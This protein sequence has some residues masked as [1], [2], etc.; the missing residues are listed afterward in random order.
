MHGWI[1]LLGA[2]PV[3]LR[4]LSV[5]FGF[6]AI[7]AIY[8]AAR[9]LFGGSRVPL[10]AAFLLA[11]NPM[12]VFYSQEVRMYGFV[13]LL[14]I[15]ILAA[16]WRVLGAADTADAAR[17]GLKPRSDTDES[18]LKPADEEETNPVHRVS[19][20]SARR[21]NAGRPGW[22]ALL[23]YVL[24]TT[25]ALYTQYYAVFLPVGLTFYALWHWRRNGRA[26]VQWLA[27]Q[28]AIALLYL[29]WVIYAAPK[30]VPYVSQKVVA[31]ADK[32]LGIIP[33]IARH[34]AAFG[35]GHLEGPLASW[36]P[37]T[38][39][40][41]LPIAVGLWLLLT[42]PPTTHP[43]TTVR[44]TQ[45]A[46]RKR[47]ADRPHYA[48][49]M[50]A[51][52]L[53]TTLALGWLI[54]LRAPF[55]PQRGERLL[56][57]ALPAF[58]LLAAGGL[59]A[60]WRRWRAIGAV[61]LGL[62]AAT[63]V[64]SLAAFYTVPRYA[65]DDYR[66]LI[67]RVTEQ[68]LPGDTVFAVYPWQV[69]YWR[70]YAPADG[71]TPLLSPEAAWGSAVADAL[72]AAL[73]QGRVW[74]P[75]HLALGGILETQAETHLA[76]AAAPF[77]NEWYGPGTRLSAWAS[78]DKN[79]ARVT[80]TDVGIRFALPEGGTLL[81]QTVSG[82]TEPAPAANAVTPIELAWRADVA[83]AVLDVSIRLT[84]DLG[85]IW[86]QHDYEP[87]GGP[88][89]Q[90]DHPERSPASVRGAESKDGWR[91]T[92]RLGL[93][94]PA[95]T[96]PGRYH[97]E[98]VIQ[99]KGSGRAIEALAQ[100][101]RILGPA[102]RLFDVDVTAADRELSP[103]RLPIA[104]RR[105][106]DLTD[107]LNFLGHSTEDA[108][109]TPGELRKISLFWQ[110]TAQ[111]A[112]DTIAFVQALGRDGSPVALWEAPPGAAYP[113][114]AWAPGTLMRTQAS[115]RIPASAPD[116]RY[117]LIAG[118]FRADDKTRL[119][120]AAGADII[121]LGTITVRGRSHRMTQ[122]EPQQP[123]DATFGSLAR[124]VG[125]D[126]AAA[127]AQPGHTLALTLHW[128]ALAATDRPYTVFVHLIDS[129]GVVRGYGDAE[130]GGGAFPTPGWLAAEYLADTHTL[131]VA[132][133]APAG[134]YRLAIGFY[135]PASGARLPTSDGADR[136]V[137]EASIRIE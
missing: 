41:L 20:F 80:N 45:Y 85:Q 73:A 60:L 134:V 136:T 52:T 8:L 36:W 39:V 37:A 15:G 47:S 6:L 21:F 17:P 43:Q 120:T 106:V 90:T 22:G 4:L 34:L 14:S 112:T 78:T 69:G 135:D 13:A 95:G 91:A 28:A 58:I 100:D 79:A 84:D 117:R 29:P 3:A 24:L 33:Y 92:D 105:T 76:G 10:L 75:A 32:P 74:F 114:S 101:G 118:L 131:A 23:A 98:L 11:I 25:A 12:H 86:A 49:L 46:T 53:L 56:I 89:F 7:P 61:T 77:I 121:A 68:G 27:A 19:T 129:A 2:D 18:R 16:A 107:G 113:T 72:D 66:P 30:L 87:L 26:L 122:P 116:G 65:D 109:L 127:E 31:D 1:G 108:M 5:I 50:L 137:L 42:R 64:A 125:Y 103:E 51:I 59:D 70:S 133:D 71:P 132:A 57:L 93:L 35:A 44:S 62:V 102:A 115:F 123:A 126:L 38:L 130:P 54:S 63:S 124:L 97:V 9:R 96:P 128:Q 40:L 94:I 55:F 81:L 48:V 104:T 82:S 67:A 99:P 110:A 119:R 83:P 88:T 111:P